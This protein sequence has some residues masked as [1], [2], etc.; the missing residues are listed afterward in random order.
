M[1]FTAHLSFQDT[2]NSRYLYPELYQFKLADQPLL[3]YLWNQITKVIWLIQWRTYFNVMTVKL[4]NR[5]QWFIDD[6]SWRNL[7]IEISWIWFIEKFDLKFIEIK[8]S[9]K[10]KINVL[11]VKYID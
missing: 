9:V 3:I 6:S 10:Y 1:G 7:K 5:D 11:G 8:L 2:E 4:Q